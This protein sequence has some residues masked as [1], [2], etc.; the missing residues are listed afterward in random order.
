[1][2][3]AVEEGRGGNQRTER[4]AQVVAAI[5]HEVRRVAS[6]L[7]SSQLV[8]TGPA[9]LLQQALGRTVS[10]DG[11]QG[12]V[13]QPDSSA[14]IDEDIELVEGPLGKPGPAVLGEE[15]RRVE[16]APVQAGLMEGV[17]AV[18]DREVAR[19]APEDVAVDVD[20]VDVGGEA[21]FGHRC[22]GPPS[23]RCSS[24]WP[25]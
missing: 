20:D 15:G 19:P 3:R 5:L 2:Q 7:E 13:Q 11:R 18:D 24:G 21:A 16:L 25:A 6:L 4:G 10:G 14:L 22:H 1:V 23:T 12:G 9:E 17:E 8:A